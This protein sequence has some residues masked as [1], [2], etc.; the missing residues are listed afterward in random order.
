M[1]NNLAKLTNKSVDTFNLSTDDISRHL[2]PNKSHGHDM[3]SIQMLKLC[4]NSVC[5]PVS[6]IFND[7]LK[8]GKFPSY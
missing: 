3:L 5:K 2:D 7:C 6:I 8:E 1:P 4:G